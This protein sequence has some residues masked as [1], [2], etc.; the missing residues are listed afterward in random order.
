MPSRLARRLLRRK[1]TPCHETLYTGGSPGP[2]EASNVQ[3]VDDGGPCI[4]ADGAD[5]SKSRGHRRF[6]QT[7]F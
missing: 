1:L 7:T 6:A 2:L 3:V 5:W 4:D